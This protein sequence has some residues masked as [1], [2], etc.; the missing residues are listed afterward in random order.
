MDETRKAVIAATEF[1]ASHG[2]MLADIETLPAGTMDRPSKIKD[3]MD[4]L[5]SPDPLRGDFFAQARLV[6]ALYQAV[7]PAPAALE[8]ASRVACISAA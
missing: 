2:V 6:S 7:K 1:C 3:A 5:I 8:F 4:A